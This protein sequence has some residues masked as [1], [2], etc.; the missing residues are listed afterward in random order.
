M[1]VTGLYAACSSALCATI[2]AVFPVSTSL[3]WR[4]ADRFVPHAAGTAPG[5]S[6]SPSHRGEGAKM[7]QRSADATPAVVSLPAEIDIT[8]AGQVY[9]LL[10]AAAATGAPVVIADC[11]ATVF[12]DVAGVRR[13]VMG[14][15][16]AAARGVQLRLV[17]APGG[18]LRRL[19]ELLG[20][21]SVLPVYPGVEEASV[22]AVHPV[23]D[24]LPLP[25]HVHSVARVRPSVL[26][27]D[28]LG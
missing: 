25:L 27:W 28:S 5:R 2:R 11:T 10:M 18:L 26:D 6:A 3:A 16:Q 14:H 13:L 12:C 20:A 7:H 15:A 4:L 22:P 19:L 8:N 17:I 21:D 24:P 9:E 1:E 23:Q